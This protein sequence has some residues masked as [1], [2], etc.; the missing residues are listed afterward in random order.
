MLRDYAW[1][2][3][4]DIPELLGVAPTGEPVAEAWW[5]AHDSSPSRAL[6]GE[7][8]TALDDLIAA[9]PEACLGADAVAAWGARLPFLL[10]VLAIAKP[11]SIQVHPSLEQARAGFAR[12]QRGTAGAPHRFHDPFHKPE[13]IVALSPMTA[14]VGVRPLDDLRADLATLDTTGAR[15]LADTLASGDLGHY[16]MAA[17]AGAADERTLEALAQ[18]GAA[19]APQSPLA[20]SAETLRSFPGDPGAMVALGMNVVTLE[21]G[22]AVYTGAGVL[23]SYQ[24]GVGVEIMAN[25]DNVVRAGLTSK[26]VDVPLLLDLADARPKPPARPSV[27]HEPGCFHLVTDAEEYALSVVSGA[28]VFEPGPRIVVAVE[29]GATV[30]GE[31]GELSLGRG[32]AAFV[33]A[34]DGDVEVRASG[35]TAVARLPRPEEREGL[36]TG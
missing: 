28:A 19:A 32:Q 17:L 4:H 29:G 35:F 10:K 7:V 26:P 34:S 20:V 5:G 25:S 14:L 8:E 27:A 1:G 22:E 3:T 24:S 6:G 2:T 30:V 31:G 23:H 15:T 11:L 36:A 16:M 21:R 9:D 18:A 33:K 12:E 13:M